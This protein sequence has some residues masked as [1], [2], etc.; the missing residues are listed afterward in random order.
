MPN[1][2]GQ[3]SPGSYRLEDIAEAR[4]KNYP[5]AYHATAKGKPSRA[6]RKSAWEEA[7]NRFLAAKG[8]ANL[9]TN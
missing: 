9:Q 6:M 8:G 7:T 5:L 2:A 3:R 1:A 4:G